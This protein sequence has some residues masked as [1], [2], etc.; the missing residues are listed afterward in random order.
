MVVVDD[1][2]RALLRKAE[3]QPIISCFSVT[4]ENEV[5]KP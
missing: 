2:R 4:S 5:L 3:V 1:L